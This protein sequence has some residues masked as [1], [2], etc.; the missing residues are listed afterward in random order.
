MNVKSYISLVEITGFELFNG[1][2]ALYS[3]LPNCNA[4]TAIY[5]RKFC[6]VSQAYWA[7]SRLI[8]LNNRDEFQD[9]VSGVTAI[10]QARVVKLF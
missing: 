2:I 10:R 9:F 7:V 1:L 6:Q 5:F 8:M 4:V 3:R